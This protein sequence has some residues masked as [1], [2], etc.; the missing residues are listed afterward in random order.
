[1]F[2][3]LDT[4]PAKMARRARLF[5]KSDAIV[6]FETFRSGSVQKTVLDWIRKDQLTEEGKD[7]DG[8]F[9]GFYSFTTAVNDARKGFNEPYDLNDTG[10][11]YRSMFIITVADALIIRGDTAKMENNEWSEGID[12]DRIL[13]LNEE[14]L[15]K[16]RRLYLE[17]VIRYAK[18]VLFE[19]F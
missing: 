6:W 9:I 7:A 1:M 19:S 16:L 18:K 10:A 3:I 17:N 11:F 15:E 12:F 13:D 4:E 5:L 8:E 2:K 14:N